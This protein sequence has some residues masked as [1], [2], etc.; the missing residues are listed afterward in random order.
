MAF[1]KRD[2]EIVRGLGKKV[3]EVAALPAQEEKRSLWRALNGLKPERPM[4]MIDQLPWHEMDVEGELT[5][6]SEDPF[7]RWLEEYFRHTLYLWKHMPVDMVV[8][9]YVEIYKVVCGTD[10]G[11][12]VE[13]Q[14]LATDPKNDVV[15]H[16][17]TDQLQTE[18]D[19]EK[20]KLPEIHYDRETTEKNLEMAHELLDGILEVRLQGCLPN[21]H[22]WD[23]ISTWKGVENALY[24]IID[25][26]E[27][28]HKLVARLTDAYIS[29]LDQLEE[30][31]L[32]GSGQTTI[33]CTGAYTDELPAPSFNPEK[34][35]AKDLWTF[36][37]AQMFST[38]SPA[39][40]QEFDL[41]YSRRWFERFGLVY[42]GCCDPLDN[43]MDIVRKIPNVRKVSM[44]PWVN[45][46]KG[47]QG[48][49]RDFVFSRKPNP[50]FLAAKQWNPV[51]VEKDLKETMD[52]CRKYGCPVEFI[53]K[54]VS[55]VCYEPQRLW[56]WAQ[57]AMRVVEA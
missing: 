15:S 52:I 21:I 50:A 26:P 36:G 34:P 14:T 31:G 12:K 55:T 8:E 16:R 6:Q 32:L 20:I 45:V 24:D 25:R 3:A 27:F 19:L 44:S 48:I 41:N 57:I 38:V 10:F 2:A 40:H 39:M 51:V 1:S 11:I 13:E 49:G 43:K 54:D 29:M 22:T 46:E 53:L 42:Y 35:R 23:Q 30:Q 5:I 9:P 37:L 33:H 4:V 56:E 18:E 17:F 47:A 7:C 28:I